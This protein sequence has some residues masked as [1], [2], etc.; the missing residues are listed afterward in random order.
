MGGS[1]VLVDMTVLYL[2]ADLKMLA[3]NVTL[4]K[5]WS[6]ETAMLNNFLWNELWTFK[7]SEEVEKAKSTVI[8]RLVK[9]HAI[10]GFGILLA[11]L[12]LHVFYTWLNINLY[13][14][15]FLAIVLVTFWNF[16]M[17]AVFNWRIGPDQQ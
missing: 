9:F 15:N 14:A 16:W 1:G 5:F 13:I 3:W 4:A 6:A 8:R 10:C 17:N 7:N 2:L 12:F 11:V